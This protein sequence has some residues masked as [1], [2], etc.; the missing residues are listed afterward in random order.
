MAYPPCHSYRQKSH[1]SANKKR[2]RSIIDGKVLVA[3]RRGAANTFLP[4]GHVEFGE[5]MRKTLIRELFEEL[6]QECEAGRY[7]GAIEHVFAED[8]RTQHEINHFFIA[9][10]SAL[11]QPSSIESFE[12]G[13]EFFWQPVDRLS[14]VNLQ[15][16]PL[17]QLLED[18]Q[19]RPGGAWW[20]S[21]L[22]QRE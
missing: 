17:V 9:V 13:L 21:T 8:G 15:P 3:R 22:G 16:Q 6:R 4:G 18:A 10:S 5:S 19:S 14:E 2:K 11:R 12:E 1:I 7:L 20:A